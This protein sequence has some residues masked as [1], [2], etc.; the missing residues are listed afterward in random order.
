MPA[1]LSLRG[2][3]TKPKND[4]GEAPAMYVPQQLYQPL[5]SGQQFRVLRKTWP[6][7]HPLGIPGG[8]RPGVGIYSMITRSI[9]DSAQFSALSYRWSNTRGTDSLL[10]ID[11]WA[12]FVGD[13]VWQFLE[14]MQRNDNSDDVFIDCLCINQKD[15]TEK[16]SQVLLMGEIYSKA[17]T[18][19]L[20][21]ASAPCPEEYTAPAALVHHED[22]NKRYWQCMKHVYDA[23]YWT[24]TWTVQ[25]FPL[26]KSVVFMCGSECLNKAGIA[27]F[28]H[29]LSSE[30]N[31]PQEHRRRPTESNVIRLSRGDDWPHEDAFKLVR[32]HAVLLFYRR[33]DEDSRLQ[34]DEE[35]EEEDEEEDDD[36]GRYNRGEEG[37]TI[38]ERD[39]KRSLAKVLM[40]HTGTACGWEQRDKVYGFLGLCTDRERKSFPV[41][42]SP[43]FGLSA[44][45]CEVMKFC[46]V[47]EDLRVWFAHNIRDNLGLNQKV[48]W[49]PP[50]PPS[51]RRPKFLSSRFGTASSKAVNPDSDEI[52]YARA[53]KVGVICHP[54]LSDQSFD[55]F[56]LTHATAEY[57][58]CDPASQERRDRLQVVRAATQD[59]TRLRDLEPP[60]LLNEE[61][62]QCHRGLRFIGAP[63][64]TTFS[65]LGTEF[66]ARRVRASSSVATVVPPRLTRYACTDLLARPDGTSETVQL[67]AVSAA[68]LQSGDVVC[69]FIGLD[70]S[71]VLRQDGDYY[72]LVGKAYLDDSFQT[73]FWLGSGSTGNIQRMT[74]QAYPHLWQGSTWIH[75]L[76]SVSTEP[77][78]NL[79]PDGLGSIKLAMDLPT[80][81]ELCW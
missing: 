4:V 12:V 22:P 72:S 52:I 3:F 48:V 61:R 80:L 42:Y 77:H 41:N 75:Y 10:I 19:Y 68:P 24:R 39:S 27:R 49:S 2:L 74:M 28:L 62:L 70:T 60:P 69:Q 25:E 16:A 37:D 13:N 57:L 21:F 40:E 54:H 81:L 32:G 18:V 78:T 1:D 8:P 17:E 59:A 51:T 44:L 34:L 56:K 66:R 15:D 43:G 29:S 64:G 50:Q 58:S 35:G 63:E 31:V 67:S 20:W 76:D 9:D 7:P 46:L 38:G 11:G 30:R 47:N 6:P 53:W 71:I 23:D 33:E 45:F 65:G 73:R 36:N 14:Q 55:A 5:L 79:V 26:A